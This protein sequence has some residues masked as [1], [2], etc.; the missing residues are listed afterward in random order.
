MFVFINEIRFCIKSS[1]AYIVQ[2]LV[3]N[4]VCIKI[5]Y[6]YKVHSESIVHEDS[7]QL[8]KFRLLVYCYS[9]YSH[10]QP[11]DQTAPVDIGEQRP[12]QYSYTRL[13]KKPVT[14]AVTSR[15]ASDLG[16]TLMRLPT[17]SWLCTDLVFIL[18]HYRK[19]L[20]SSLDLCIFL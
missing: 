15:T 3:Y 2:A 12:C 5:V 4:S 11:Y 19:L 6:N 9:P 20:T 16:R 8:L 7:C 14:S 18:E 1:L 17:V 13:A 10:A